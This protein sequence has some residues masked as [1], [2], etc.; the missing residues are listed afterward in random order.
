MRPPLSHREYKALR[1]LFGMVALW[2]SE[3]G[4]LKKRL[5]GI[6]GGWRDA[7]MIASV[8]DKLLRKI[9]DTVPLKKLAMIRKELRSTVCEVV[10]KKDV[11]GVT[12]E[13]FTYVEQEALERI[14]S[15]A[16]EMS[17]LFCEKCGKEARDCQLRKDVER[18]YMWDFPKIH[19]G[20]PCPFAEG[21]IERND[22]NDDPDGIPEVSGSDD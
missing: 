10:V 17:C 12:K 22:S 4:E 19:D 9:L 16:M 13:A 7:R 5:A 15:K 20:A 6:P 3:S 1:Q 11:T 21:H 18:L 8:S 14:T 2:D